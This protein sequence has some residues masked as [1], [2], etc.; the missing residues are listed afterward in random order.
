M[1][2]VMLRFLNTCV[3]DFVLCLWSDQSEFLALFMVSKCGNWSRF[4]FWVLY[5][6]FSLSV[7]IFLLLSMD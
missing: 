3:L 4:Y 7:A 1:V 2:L 5:F 6:V